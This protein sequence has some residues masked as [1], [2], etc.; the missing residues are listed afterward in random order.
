MRARRN[1]RPVPGG[2]SLL[3]ALDPAF[4]PVRHRR[5]RGRRGRLRRGTGDRHAEESPAGIPSASS[6]SI[7]PSAPSRR[8]RSHR[9]SGVSFPGDGARRT[10]ASAAHGP[11]GRTSAP[12]ASVDL[13][14]AFGRRADGAQEQTSFLMSD[15]WYP[16]LWWDGL[17]GHDAYSVKLDIPA[18]F[19]VAA[20]GRLDPRTGRYEA[21][22]ART[23]G[24]YLAPGLK[25]ATREVDGVLITAYFTEQGRRGRR[26]LPGDRRR[27]RPFLQGLAGLL[28][29]SVPE[30]HPRRTGALGRLPGRDRHRGHPRPG[31][32]CRRRIAA[33][34]AAHHLARDRAR[35][36][37]RVGPRSGR[38]RLDMDRT[39]HLR[40]HRVHD[41]ARLRSGPRRRM[42][43]ELR[44]R[45]PDVLRHYAGRSGRP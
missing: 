39:G 16:R 32:L 6:P 35:V 41:R 12:G 26:R 24:L 5:P 11:A 8:S 42:D 9:G 7:G 25:S 2:R 27:R 22:A 28:P 18:G 44:R 43:R 34:L 14:V 40:G 3:R 21:S 15:L 17:Q 33:A 31:D 45:R 20:S 1:G 4:Q 23:F 29:L 19:T 10:P 13:T 30:H 36:L 37:G 38:P